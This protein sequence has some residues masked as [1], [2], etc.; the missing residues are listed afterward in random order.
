MPEAG[1]RTRDARAG[2]AGGAAGGGTALE[3]RLRAGA[4]RLRFL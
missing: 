4:V 2:V 1:L 3:R